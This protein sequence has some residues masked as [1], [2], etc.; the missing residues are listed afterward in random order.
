MKTIPELS[1]FPLAAID[2]VATIGSPQLG[3]D[4][5]QDDDQQE[6]DEFHDCFLA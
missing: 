4:I 5:K 2:A 3:G 6:D 1:Q